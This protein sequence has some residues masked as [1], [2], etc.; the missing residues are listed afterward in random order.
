[1]DSKAW[2]Q[3]DFH[4]AFRQWR[5][6]WDVPR[7]V[8]A[9]MA[10]NRLLLDLED[11]GQAELLRAEIDRLTRHGAGGEIT[12][13]EALPG[14]QDAWLEGPGGAYA[15]ELVVSLIRRARQSTS[16]SS[17]AAQQTQVADR[18][19][20]PG[21]EWLFV[22]LYGSRGLEDDFIGGPLRDFASAALRRGLANDWFYIRYADPDHH[23]RVRFKGVPH[24]LMGE[25]LPA[26]AAWAGRLVADGFCRR[27]SVDTYE[28]ELERYGGEAGLGIAEGI[29]CA[30][31][32]A[33]VDL[34]ALS[35][36]GL[37]RLDRIAL[38]LV[39]LDDLFG[40][41]ELAEGE[42][43]DWFR[44]NIKSRVAGVLYRERKD[45]FRSLIREPHSSGSEVLRVLKARREV[46]SPLARKL[47]VLAGRP[48]LSQAP[49]VIYRSHLHLHCNRL[50]GN[51]HGTERHVM[52]LLRRT[53]EG[54]FRKPVASALT[55]KTPR[56]A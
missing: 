7:Y 27:W 1:M 15:H 5:D 9:G 4:K 17:L 10:D 42:R 6:V 24:R 45:E 44:K 21:S 2:S 13:Q 30:D 14:P 53:S 46:I 16:R 43:M 8:Y 39:S 52:E 3:E 11:A 26:L 19:R 12:V 36:R 48:E 28:R 37:T 23:L 32:R 38:A 29:F 56:D 31:S 18:L 34:L 40:S 20:L 22:K 41:F 47:R 33:T 55:E 35:T 25:L 54:L 50:L 51:D 49:E